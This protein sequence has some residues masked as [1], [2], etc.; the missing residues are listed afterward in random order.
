MQRASAGDDVLD[1]VGRVSASS[2]GCGLAMLGGGS[3]VTE[4]CAYL[5]TRMGNMSI[6]KRWRIRMRNYW[7]VFFF[8]F[9]KN[10]NGEERW[11][12]TGVAQMVDVGS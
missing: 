7:R 4:A 12:T 11:E 5:H 8:F 3:G 9:Q 1:C 2:R 10:K 6:V